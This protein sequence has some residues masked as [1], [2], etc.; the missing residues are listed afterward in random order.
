MAAHIAHKHL[1]LPA[2]AHHAVDHLKRADRVRADEPVR[3]FKQEPLVRRAQ[4]LQNQRL[5]QARAVLLRV[6]QAHVQD[7]P[8][9]AHAALRRARDA[10]KRRLLS[11]DPALLK[12]HAQPRDDLV[13]GNTAKVK[14]LAAGEDRRRELLRLRRRQNEDDVG[15]RLLQRLEQ[16]V[17]R[18]L[19]KHV[20]LVDDVDAVAARLR[21][22]LHLLAQVADLVHAVVARRVDLQD[23]Q[24]ALGG[25]RSARRALPARLAAVRIFT[26]HRA[27]EHLGRRG[28]ARAAR[29]AEQ[30]RV[31]DASAHH[32]AA[33][34][35]DDGL[36]PHKVVKP[37]RT[38]A[39]V[40]RLI[41]HISASITS[42]NS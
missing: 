5:R 38:I 12:R 28:L 16:R 14:A 37:R 42:S 19:G 21:R 6:A 40:Q 26:V 24:A 39:A 10:G 33:Q 29:A 34:R 41:T 22:I 2:R 18:A 4:H 13:R 25:K 27:R 3:E 35:S 15:G 20:H 36:L 9:V 11:R 8:G 1:H 7:R 31:R 30:I 32:L 23:V 17:E